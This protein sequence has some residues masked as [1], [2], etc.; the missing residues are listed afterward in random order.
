MV[1]VVRLGC[2]HFKIQVHGSFF[3]ATQLQP[4]HFDCEIRVLSDEFRTIARFEW[5]C[6]WT[7][8]KLSNFCHHGY[9]EVRATT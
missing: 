8:F 7:R 1:E 6:H 2:I 5:I 9:D 3:L 4:F